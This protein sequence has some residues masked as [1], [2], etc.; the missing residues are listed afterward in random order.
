MA[1]HNLSERQACKVLNLSHSVFRYQGK[2]PDD[3]EIEK[4]LLAL[5]ARKPRC[6]VIRML[7]MLITWKGCP[8]QI[9]MDN[10]PE[11]ISLCLERWAEERKIILGHI[12]PGKPAQNDYT[13]RFNRTFCED[14]L[15]AYLFSS[16]NEARE[17]TEQRLVR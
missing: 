2:K 16:I 10:G 11:L 5:A 17:I 1:G 6:G 8:Y 15:D 3:S 7:E 4:E 12:Q 14:A 9:R 13:E